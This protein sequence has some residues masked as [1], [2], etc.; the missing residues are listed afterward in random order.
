MQNIAIL[1]L[2]AGASIRMGKPK[3]TEEIRGTNLIERALNAVASFSNSPQLIVLG[4]NKDIY[5]PQIKESDINYE[6]NPNWHNGISTSINVGIEWFKRRYLDE[7]DGVLILLS[8]MPLVDSK[9]LE[10]VFQQAKESLKGIVASDYGPSLGPPVIFDKKYFQELQELKGDRGAK[11]V[12]LNHKD[13][14]HVLDFPEGLVD[15]D[16]PEDLE[17]FNSSQ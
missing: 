7:I 15:I 13:D 1:I 6:I 14:L 16:T 11:S 3:L 12:I 2:A 10:S 17:G 9:Y 8:D 4:G 5:L